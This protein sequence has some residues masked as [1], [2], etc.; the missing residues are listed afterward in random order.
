M[1]LI[2][3]Q[4]PPLTFSQRVGH[5]IA[6]LFGW[7]VTV[8]E[9]IPQKCVIVGA[10]HTSSWDLALTLIL[11]LATGLPF[12]FVVKSSLHRGPPGWFMRPLGA[13]PVDRSSSQGFVRELAAAFDRHDTYR[14]AILP[15][16][17]RAGVTYWRTGFYHLALAAGVPIVLGFGDYRRKVVGLG[18]ILRPSGDIEADFQV[19]RRFYAGVTARH[20]DKQGEVRLRPENAEG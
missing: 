19:I 4:I 8:D 20:P 12:H 2:T 17:S 16:G 1:S 18:P 10:H 5:A 11:R 9:P 3:S 14:V 13:I 15:E 6:S 7:Q